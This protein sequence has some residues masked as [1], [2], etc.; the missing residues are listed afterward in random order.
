MI[1]QS[2]QS[3]T[4]TVHVRF[5]YGEPKSEPVTTS[6]VEMLNKILDKA[7]ELSPDHRELLVKF[8]DYINGLYKKEQSPD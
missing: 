3:L 4:A 2:P 7:S 8:A 1:F 5:N 6:D